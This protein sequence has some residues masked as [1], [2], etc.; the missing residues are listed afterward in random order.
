MSKDNKL[1]K[2]WYAFNGIYVGTLGYSV[3]V[4]Y[5]EGD[6]NGLFMC[7]VAVLTLV[8]VPLI[9]KVFHFKPVYEIYLVATT[10][11]YIA[12]VWGS[13]LGGYGVKGF[14]KF[15]HFSSGF[16]GLT[17]A[18]MLYY[19]LSSHNE[20][21]TVPEKRV[22]YVFINAVNMAIAVCWEFF[23]YAMLIFFNND[24]I[25]H[26][27][28]GVHDSMTDMLCATFAGLLLTMWIMKKNSNFFMNTAQKFYE[29]NVKK[30]P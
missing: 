22:F 2:I 16:L 21:K 11:A 12:S 18:V 29:L 20:I 6:K 3:F 7:A 25:N 4:N 15:L 13:T 8:L 28:Q 27:T 24:A 1:K 9:F 23:E 17:A 5:V 19:L 10:F 14:D 30:K 26:Y